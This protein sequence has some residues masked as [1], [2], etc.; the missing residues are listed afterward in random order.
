MTSKQKLEYIENILENMP[1]FTDE[2]L[3]QFPELK[4]RMRQ[5]AIAVF[6]DVV[7]MP[8]KLLDELIDVEYAIKPRLHQFYL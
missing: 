3:D 8:M 7:S 6:P 4:L 2:D 1:V 5:G